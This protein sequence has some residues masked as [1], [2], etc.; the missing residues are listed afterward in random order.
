MGG[1]VKNQNFRFYDS[2]DLFPKKK[3]K[4]LSIVD[5][6]TEAQKKI[7]ELNKEIESG[8]FNR[9]P[10][11]MKTSELKNLWELL[12]EVRQKHMKTETEYIPQKNK[13]NKKK[14][15]QRNQKSNLIGQ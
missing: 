13:V 11:H 3:N 10:P 14:K 4:I 1:N 6:I 9:P 7:T 8:S 12:A 5:C 15:L 2:N